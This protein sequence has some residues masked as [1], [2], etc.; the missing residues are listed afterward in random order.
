MFAML[1]LLWTFYLMIFN[2]GFV[3]MLVVYLLF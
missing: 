2:F 3:V 1:F